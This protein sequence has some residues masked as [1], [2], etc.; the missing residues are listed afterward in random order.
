MSAKDRIYT[1]KVGEWGLPDWTV[2]KDR[3]GTCHYLNA[4]A[5]TV[6]GEHTIE[7]LPA[8]YK[9]NE[10]GEIIKV[11]QKRY[12]NGKEPLEIGMWFI[13]SIH[14]SCVQAAYINGLDVAFDYKDGL[15]ACSINSCKPI[16]TRTDKQ[17]AVD[18]LP[19]YTTNSLLANDIIDAIISGEVYGVKWVGKDETK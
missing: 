17:K 3:F 15:S 19:L 14:Q 8:G 12:W 18:S 6:Q 10:Q 11:E 1:G 9:F 2:I 16:D 7:K 4:L 13:E 5:D